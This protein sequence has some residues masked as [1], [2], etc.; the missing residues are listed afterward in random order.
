MY[1]VSNAELINTERHSRRISL[2]RIRRDSTIQYRF[3]R[4]VP[5]KFN[6]TTVILSILF[7]KIA[8]TDISFNKLPLLNCLE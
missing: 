6:F 3:V 8:L 5:I 7:Y 1:T 4:S 2:I